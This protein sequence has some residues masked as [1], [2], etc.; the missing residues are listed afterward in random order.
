MVLSEIVV[1]SGLG[2]LSSSEVE[3]TASA[4]LVREG[5]V[6]MLCYRLVEECTFNRRPACENLSGPW[7]TCFELSGALYE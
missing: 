5:V 4:T 3:E 2:L 7:V 6:D 1:L